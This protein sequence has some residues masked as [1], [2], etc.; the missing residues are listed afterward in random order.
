MSEQQIQSKFIKHL[1]ERGAY[2]IK[3]ITASR[4]G[5]LD[6]VICYKGLFVGIE[7]KDTGKLNE[8]SPLQEYNL[9]KIKDCG[10]QSLLCD[11][12]S[13]LVEFFDYLDKHYQVIFI[14]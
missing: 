11:K 7:V 3:V 1:E 14:P 12:L 4:K 10:G 13:N 6:L 5:V 9:N 2:V 8:V